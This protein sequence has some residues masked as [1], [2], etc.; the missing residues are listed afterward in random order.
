MGTYPVSNVSIFIKW[1]RCSRR[2][3]GRYR[4]M[5]MGTKRILVHTLLTFRSKFHLRQCCLSR[6]TVR[7]HRIHFTI[8]GIPA[9]KTIIVCSEAYY[10]NNIVSLPDR[11]KSKTIV[12]AVTMLYR[13]SYLQTLKTNIACRSRPSI[14]ICTCLPT[15]HTKRAKRGTTTKPS[16]NINPGTVRK[17]SSRLYLSAYGHTR[18]G[19]REPSRSG[20]GVGNTRPFLL[21][22]VSDREERIIFTGI[23]L[24]NCL[25]DDK[26]V[27]NFYVVGHPSYT[28]LHNFL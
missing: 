24:Y 12:V 21:A 11:S 1:S 6:R 14:T 5:R 18:W 13:T 23:I 9:Y 19:W 16:S 4:M 17:R 27:L 8:T 22:D 7:F 20:R 28:R 15:S 10:D 25:R 3:V 26:T 2:V